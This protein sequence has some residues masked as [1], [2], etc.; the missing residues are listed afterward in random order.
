M[1]ANGPVRA[2]ID[3]LSLVIEIATLV[4]SFEI[5][6]NKVHWSPFAW[7]LKVVKIV[8]PCER[9]SCASKSIWLNLRLLADTLKEFGHSLQGSAIVQVVG[10]DLIFPHVI[11]SGF[12]LG[13]PD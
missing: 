7:P 5:L 12:P 1:T 6:M 9:V 2:D 11:S 3:S 4:D 13:S 10:D 8:H